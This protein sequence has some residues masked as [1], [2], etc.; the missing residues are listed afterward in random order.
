LRDFVQA[1]YTD[2][3]RTAYLLAGS[4]HEAEDLVQSALLRMTGRWER[5]D[6]PLAYARRT[7]VN[8]YLNGLRRR[9]RELVT[10][11]LPERGVREG[12]DRVAD[13]SALWPALRALPPRTRAVIV[14]RYWMDLSEVE[15]AQLLDC[16]VGTVK[17][18]A[19]RGL[20]RLREAVSTVDFSGGG[21]R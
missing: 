7:I 11:L 1:R 17:S 10:A 9:R 19:S 18:T 12:T 2:L 8:L 5:I 16:S 15:T 21:S 4:S 20:A 13:R 3:L 14:A 6:D